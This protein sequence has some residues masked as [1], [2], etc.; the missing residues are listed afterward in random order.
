MNGTSA[1]R[2]S[3][4][5]N[6]KELAAMGDNFEFQPTVPF[7]HWARS[8]DVLYQEA[9]FA[10][11]DHDYR[12]AYVMLWR[13]SSLVLKHLDTH[14]DAKL[15][16]NK[17]FTKALRKR[18]ANEV[19]RRLEQ[20]KPLIDSEY[21]EWA[22][23][24]AASKKAAIEQEDSKPTTYNDF[25]ARDPSLG[26]R[27]R[28]LDAGDNQEFAVD[29]AQRDF[30]RRDTI[31]RGIRRAGISVEQEQERRRGGTWDDWQGG[32][33]DTTNDAD[34]LRRQMEATRQ[35]LDDNQGGYQRVE[36]AFSHTRVSH[37][38]P[39]SPP[40]KIPSQPYHYPSVSKPKPV[41]WDS[42]PLEPRRLDIAAPSKPPKE[43]DIP[44]NKQDVVPPSRPLKESLPTYKRLP[45]PEPAAPAA[46][47]RPPKEHEVEAPAKEQRVA[48]RPA[49]Y[50]ENGDPIRPVFIPSDLR[51]KFLEIASGN[52]RKGLEMCGI[53]CG[54]PINN[55]LFIS[56]LLIPEQ[57]CTSDTCETENESAQLE[58]CINEDLLV[59][60]WIHTHPTQTCFM[61]SRDLH[62][63]AG[64]QIMMPESIAIV[65]AP[66]HQPSHGIFRLTNPPGLPHILNCNQAAMFHQHHI[67]NIYTKASNPPGHVFQSD[68]LH[69]YVKD[70]RPKN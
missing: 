59:L 48:F 25:A 39:P 12:K 31:K 7:K 55:A 46:P 33:P 41:Q 22:R 3:R 26:G 66:Q 32:Q 15:P 6:T 50:L 13:H 29:L 14:P 42:A 56:C 61:S 62:T 60:G 67:D 69:W 34:E 47:T 4:P 37:P 18:Q 38:H 21:D 5:T 36:D 24:T 54:R 40:P 64:Y 58:Y 11:Q 43:L 35:R 57:K 30:I 1:P 63:Q 68:K 52:T 27:A 44:P 53:L 20:L 23:M 10:M 49:A 45:T 9:G 16:E 19:F 51:H 8:A 28:V 17:A 65:C 2:P 70:L